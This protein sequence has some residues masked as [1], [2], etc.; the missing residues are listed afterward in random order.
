MQCIA[1]FNTIPVSGIVGFSSSLSKALNLEVPGLTEF[2]QFPGPRSIPTTQADLWMRIEG[3]S[4]AEIA[5]ASIQVE[6]KLKDRFSK[7]RMVDGFKYDIGRDLTGYEDGT[8]N[9]QGDAAFAA[10]MVES[11]D[12]T[13]QSSFVV[14]QQWQHDFATFNGLTESEQDNLMGRHKTTNEEFDA[15]ASAHVKRTAQEDFD[16]QAFMVRRSMPWSDT[17]GSGLMFVAFARSFYPFEAQMVR[18]SGAEDGIVDGLFEFSKPITGAY[19]WCP[20]IDKNGDLI[21]SDQES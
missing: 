12:F 10:A 4:I 8:E 21:L 18:M 3:E 13:N 6:L 15:P 5:L 2:P 17:N 16:P 7:L 1:Y 14:V 9:P 20:A 11:E 19:Y